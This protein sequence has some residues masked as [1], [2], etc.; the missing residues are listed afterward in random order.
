MLA[1]VFFGGIA[2]ALV[3]P[4]VPERTQLSESFDGAVADAA[5]ALRTAISRGEMMVRL[6]FDT[7]LGDATYTTLKNSIEF[8]KGL[9][10]DWATSVDGRLCLF[11]PD[12][13]AA[14]LAANQWKMSTE[15]SLV[16]ENVRV[17]GFPRDRLE[18]GDRAILVVCPRASEAA[19]TEK[20]VAEAGERFIPLAMLNP[21]L[22]DMGTTGFGLAGRMLRERLI[23]K[24]TQV[25]CLKTLEWGALA[26]TYPM[27]Y[28]VYQRDPAVPEGYKFLKSL[29]RLPNSDDL[30]E[31]FEEFNPA[32][33]DDDGPA[34]GGGNPLANFARSFGKFVDGFSKL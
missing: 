11:F 31:I 10:A 29:A 15:E 25:Y 5:S 8:A 13:G 14:A 18:D 20:L 23:D 16:P 17:A 30:E 28:S 33:G 22:V 1:I 7:T 21:E 4:V 26:K 12:S 32:G 19:A 34:G 2:T 27:P 9:S 3:A 6:D 24:L